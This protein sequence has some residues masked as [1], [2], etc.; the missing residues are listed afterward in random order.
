MPFN[1]L[2]KLMLVLLL[3]HRGLFKQLLLAFIIIET[4][5]LVTMYFYYDLSSAFS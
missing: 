5:G 4:V 1:T 3:G 2:M